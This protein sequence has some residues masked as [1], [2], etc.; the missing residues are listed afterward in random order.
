MTEIDIQTN[1]Y[2]LE[3]VKGYGHRM[4]TEE[5]I[6]TAWLAFLEAR[7]TYSNVEGCCSFLAYAGFC[8]EESLD[9]MRK[10]RNDRI[11]LE[12][13][14]SPDQPYGDGQESMTERLFSKQGDFTHGVIL[15]A[16]IEDLSKDKQKILHLMSH[17][18]SHREIMQKCHLNADQ[19][20]IVL[21]ELQTLFRGWLAI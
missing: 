17:S 3:Q 18:Y 9:L 5:S 11:S 16:F 21:V 7:H 13:P 1:R 4:D 14:L 8:I 19:F 20:Y 10:K 12:S 6:S 2:I 15:R